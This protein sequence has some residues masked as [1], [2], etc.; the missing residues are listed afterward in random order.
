MRVYTCAFTIA[1]PTLL[2]NL[3]ATH[4]S[5]GIVGKLSMSQGGACNEM[6]SLCLNV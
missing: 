5:F 6:V 3:S 1:L 4:Y 2:P